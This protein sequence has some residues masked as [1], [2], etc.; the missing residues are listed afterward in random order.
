[1]QLDFRMSVIFLDVDGVINIMSPSYNTTTIQPDGKTIWVESH[2]IK[3]L[4]WL[5][6]QTSSDV[7]I[8]SSWRLDMD[9][10]SKLMK[11]SGFKNQNKVIGYTP[12][13]KDIRYRGDE[14][15][16]WI[17]ENNYRENYVV[18]ED[19][20]DDVNGEKCTTIPKEN[21]I[22]VDPKIGLTH[23]NVQEAK[24]ILKRI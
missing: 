4:D 21:I 3:R 13:R 22:E 15:Q 7:V 10:L 14:I 19:E 20:I 24:N 12:Y 23:Q 5:I 9:D 1:M 16:A 17:D 6:D 18:L 11:K 2:L 8:S